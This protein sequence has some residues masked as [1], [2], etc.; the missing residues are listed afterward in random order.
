MG[1]LKDIARHIKLTAAGVLDVEIE[2]F[3]NAGSFE[4]AT[5]I[6]IDQIDDDLKRLVSKTEIAA[7][8]ILE[9]S[10][11]E[12]K[13]KKILDANMF[14]SRVDRILAYRCKQ[15][16]EIANMYKVTFLDKEDRKNLEDNAL[17]YLTKVKN[18]LD[19]INRLALIS[20]NS[21]NKESDVKLYNY[22]EMLSTLTWTD[23]KD[24]LQK[25]DVPFRYT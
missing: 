11:K 22:L 17:K 1:F 7:A 2:L 12:D 9:F 4:R 15:Y 3:K 24:M 13:T 18:T 16:T 19:L 14:A 25:G 21:I 23:M 20:L 8:T 5:Q 6:L 10:R